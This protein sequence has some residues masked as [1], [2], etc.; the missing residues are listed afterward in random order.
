MMVS[1]AIKL[2]VTLRNT[3]ALV[4]FNTKSKSY[5]VVDCSRRSFCR[6]YISKNCPPYCEIIVAVKDFALKRR[7]PKAEVVE[8]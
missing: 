4:L 3:R 8:L 6:I 7:K 5:R 2:S 1:E